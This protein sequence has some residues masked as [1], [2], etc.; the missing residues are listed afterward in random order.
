M[1]DNLLLYISAAKD[2]ISERDLIGR[3][4]T[5]IPVSLGWNINFSPLKGKE[6][7]TNAISQA[8]IHILILGKD[9]RAPIG[10]EWVIS[11]RGH[12]NPLLFLKK[13]VPRTPAAHDFVRT[14]K[15]FSSWNSYVDHAELRHKILQVISNHILSKADFFALSPIEYENLVDWNKE[16]EDQTPKQIEETQGGA[17]ESSV[18]ISTERFVPKDGVLLQSSNQDDRG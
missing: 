2:L 4:V 9:I 1:V 11:R 7:D 6:L 5:E 13:D 8:D 17:G 14:L 10:Y 16:L 12:R 18:I 15:D 3:S